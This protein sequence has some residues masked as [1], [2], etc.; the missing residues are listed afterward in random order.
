MRLLAFLLLGVTLATAGCLG[1]EQ[2]QSTPIGEGPPGG[3]GDDSTASGL[4]A[5]NAFEGSV[6]GGGSGPVAFGGAVGDFQVP[7]GATHAVV[8]LTWSASEPTLSGLEL[9]LC[10]GPCA[11]DGSNYVASETGESPL[12]LEVELPSSGALSW[13]VFPEGA[14]SGQ[15]FK[16][17]AGFFAGEPP[18]GYTGLDSEA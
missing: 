12:R 16:G 14:T 18:A 6:Q 3:G 7:A 2:A 9:D 8:E 1:G 17:V 15:P 10:D 11:T 5:T 4:L 13:A